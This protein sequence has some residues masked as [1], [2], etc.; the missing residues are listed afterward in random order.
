MCVCVCVRKQQKTSQPA[1]QQRQ[2]QSPALIPPPLRQHQL[3][4]TWE[5]LYSS[6]ENGMSFNR[7]AHHILGY[8][9]PTAIVLRDTAGFVFGF[10]TAE[11]WKESN[12]YYG[13]SECF[14]FRC[15]GRLWGGKKGRGGGASWTCMSVFGSHVN[16]C[17][18]THTRN[19]KQKA[20]SFIDI[21]THTKPPHQSGWSRPSSRPGPRRRPRPSTSCTSTSRVSACPT[22][23]AWAGASTAA[24]AF[25]C[26]S[27]WR[28]AW[29]RRRTG[30][31]ATAPWRGASTLTWRRS[32]WGLK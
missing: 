6:D 14:L 20:L 26:P 16:I 15:V 4:G 24:S 11:A 32:R 27:R 21:Y 3:Q 22:A 8:R 17:I 12:G 18:H 23:W 31:L 5:R 10:Y 28:A 7:V 25:S 29:R 1:S 2:P 19:S 30:P 9:G 13:S